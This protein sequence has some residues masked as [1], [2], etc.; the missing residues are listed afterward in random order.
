MTS[1]S[2]DSED[3]GLVVKISNEAWELN[4]R[5]PAVDLVALSY[6][7]DADWSRRQSIAAGR[8]AGSMVFWSFDGTSAWALIGDDDEAWDVGIRVPL[9]V[10]E[11]IVVAARGAA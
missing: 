3:E 11:H 8:S 5:A 9:D 7:R 10:I 6:I 2:V 1:V 4:V